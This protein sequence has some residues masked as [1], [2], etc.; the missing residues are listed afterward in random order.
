MIVVKMMGNL[1]NQMFIYAMARSLQ[2]RYGDDMIID[3]SGLKRHY[4]T[5][6]YKLDRFD[7]PKEISY[8]T[9]A[10]S[11]A[12]RIKYALSSRIFHLEHYYYRKTR[13]DLAIPPE[14]CLRWFRRGCYYCTNRPYFDYPES[15]SPNKYVYGYFQA[16]EYFRPYREQIRTELR[17]TDP[18]SEAD[19]A[20]MD[21]MAGC[22]SVGVSIR[23]QRAPENDKVADNLKLGLIKKEF[24]Y[25]GM[26]AIAQKVSDPVFYVF[27]DDLSAVRE[28]FEFPYPVIYVD[29]ADS[30]AG[31]RLLYSCKHFVITNST[32]AWWGAYLG[33]SPDK[34]IVM[35]RPW[36]RF[37]APRECIYPEGAICLP[38]EFEEK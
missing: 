26:R 17:V 21:A 35:P 29:P 8:R 4:Y 10:L 13:E 30:V 38:C 20:L 11:P 18:V 28:Q 24:Y 1:G 36:D 2:L 9:E 16:E 23:A 7:L 19:R 27:A 6:D 31:M 25:E 37:G 14:V 15:H 12:S 33:D 3:L 34:V 5:A 22:T 32:F